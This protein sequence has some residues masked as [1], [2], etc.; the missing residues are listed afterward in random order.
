MNEQ[1]VLRDERTMAV[2]N[3][4]YRLAYLVLSFG[5]LAIVTYRGFFRQESNWD[6]M[7]LVILSSGIATLYQSRQ[8]IFTRRTIWMMAVSA[9]ASAVLAVV[10]VLLLR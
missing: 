8:K 10:L 2:E 3:Q 9:V 1:P 6:L 7:A 4:S 5:V